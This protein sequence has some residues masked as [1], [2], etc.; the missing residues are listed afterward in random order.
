[1]T[2]EA[3]LSLRVTDPAQALVLSDPHSLKFLAPFVGRNR[4]ASHAAHE[5]EVSLHRMIYWVKRLRGIGLI[6]PSSVVGRTRQYRAVADAFFVPFSATN[7]ETG[8]QLLERWNKPWHD[9]FVANFL[10]ELSSVTPD[11]GVRLQRSGEH[12]HVALALSEKHDF[13]FFDPR[14]PNVLDGWVTN[15][16]LDP[17]DAKAMQLEVLG[18]YLKYLQRRGAQRY[19]ARVSFAP[20]QGAD[21]PFSDR[22]LTPTSSDEGLTN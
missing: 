3:A 13:N 11:F 7:A 22:D 15:L 18:V 1:V 16:Y 14:T 9:I 19:M 6:H 12:L 5:L 21:A 20:M 8:E 10:R 4:S 2:F 17:S